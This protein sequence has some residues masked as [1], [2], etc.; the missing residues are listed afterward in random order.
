MKML[1]SGEWSLKNGKDCYVGHVPGDVT[2]DLY[3]AGAIDAPYFGENY[4][5]YLWIV[6][7]DWDYVREFVVHTLPTDGENAYLQLDGVDTYAAVYVNGIC[8]GETKSM[9]RGYKFP[10]EGALQLGKNTVT[11]KLFNVYDKIGREDQTK[12]DSIF[13]ANRIFARKAQCHFGW[14]WAPQLPGYGIYRDISLVY[15]RKDSIQEVGISANMQG[16]ATFRIGFG[17]KYTGELKITLYY[18]GEKVAEET[19]SVA[20]K[21]FLTNVRV[22][23]PKLWWP[24]GYG[25]PN[26]YS[27]TI[28]R[29]G[30]N[31]VYS[32]T[33]GFR[34]IRVVRDVLDENNL[35]FAF[36][37]NGRKIFSRG[38]N[39]VPAECMTGC[40]TKEKYRALLLAAKQAN[41]NML[42]V[43]GGGI[44]E[45]DDFYAY[46]DEL[47]IMV[48][49]EFMF[50][51]SE[52]PEDDPAFLSEITAEA[53][54]QVKRLR[55]HPSICFWCGENEIRGAFC[56]VVEERYS[57]F[58]LHYLL[59]GITGA[60]TPDV[61]YERTSPFCYADTEDNPS[62]GD[63][64]AN[65][66]EICLFSAS[67]KGFDK[68]EYGEQEEWHSLVDRLKNYER[69][70]AG[71]K[72]NFS[73]EC[74]VLGMCNYE[75]L[76]KFTPQ[77][78]LQLYSKFFEERFL[79]NPYTYVMPTFFER[80]NKIAEGLYGKPKDVKD[81][82]KKI[83]KAQMDIMTT[84]IVFCRSNERSNGILSWMYN[85]IWPT[86]TWSAVD[87][88]LSK[89]PV[90]YAMKRCYKPLMTEIIR[91]D[92]R[93]YLCLANNT[94]DDVTMSVR[95]G[96]ANY[97]GEKCYEREDTISLLRDERKQIELSV[98]GDYLYALFDGWFTTYDLK[99]YT[100]D[101]CPPIYEYK[102]EEKNTDEYE[103]TVKAETYVRC[104]RIV[105][106]DANAEIENNYFDIPAGMTV[107]V[108][109]RG[110]AKPTVQTFADE[111]DK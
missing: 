54:W 94:E 5:K 35:D 30:D 106:D 19:K 105:C 66:S 77:E 79:G 104:F 81:L 82:V 46:C 50:A 74:A 8:I 55:N 11:V 96:A 84:E 93:Y 67:F 10:V 101:T 72:N 100:Q 22:E 87:Y 36:E 25:E 29:S 48:W 53:E 108:T 20:A 58:T 33:F 95:Y 37:I 62:E 107:Q 28:E 13:C 41:Y 21:K 61:P 70:I 68:F 64:H 24:N 60:L 9:H 109:V 75:S 80:Q 52:I 98:D 86:G 90:Y 18:R 56:D 1:L 23:N 91:I 110:K 14:D 42:R 111:W 16:D 27:Y 2:N 26:I 45:S 102:V 17:E 34:Q 31:E 6:N 47:G 76:V 32:G 7:T 89:K 39:W 38:S 65:L 59:R 49:Q 85:D 73:S 92:D 71:T 83:N 78:D 43:W 12:Y 57:H 88:Y 99:R 69:F 4:K 40:I 15:E 103:V 63:S 44:Y 3:Q 51:C 97:Q